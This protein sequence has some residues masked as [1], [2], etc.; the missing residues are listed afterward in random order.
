METRNLL[1][2][3]AVSRELLIT[4]MKDFGTPV[5]LARSVKG[6]VENGQCQEKL[7]GVLS[8]LLEGGKVIP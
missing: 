8:D 4:V 2:Q 6:A 5:K 7:Q 1:E 3:C